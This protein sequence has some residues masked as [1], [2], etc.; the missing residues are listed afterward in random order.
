MTVAEIIAETLAKLDLRYPKPDGDQRER[1]V[2]MR[3]LLDEED[4]KQS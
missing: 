1:Q 4:G 3:T 2:Q